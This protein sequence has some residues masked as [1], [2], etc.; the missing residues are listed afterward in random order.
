MPRATSFTLLS[1]SEYAKF[2]HLNPLHFAGGISASVVDN[3]C[4][5]VWKQWSWQ[6]DGKISR[7]R[8]AQLIQEAERDI[9][10]YLGYWPAPVWIEDERKPY[11]RLYRRDLTGY[12]QDNRFRYRNIHLDYGKVLYGGRRAT[13][14]LSPD[15]VAYTLKDLDGDGFTETAEFTLTVPS[16]LDPCEV[17]LYFKEYSAG[18]AENCRTDPSSTG[19]DFRWEIRPIRT[20]LSGTILTI[21]TDSWELFKPQLQEGFNVTAIDADDVDSYVDAV[22]VYREYNDPSLPVQFLWGADIYCDD[23]SGACSWIVQNGCM[24]ID[25]SKLGLVTLSP[26]T[27]N[28]STGSFTASAWSQGYEPDGV[29][30]WYR[31]GATESTS[32]C[33]VLDRFWADTIA[34]LATA[35]LDFP[36]CS[37][38][39]MAQRVSDKWTVDKAEITTARTF[40]APPDLLHCPFGTRAGEYEA[41][42]RIKKR[43]LGRVTLT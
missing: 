42:K 13:E 25:N 22:L 32:D 10:E 5:D 9:V 26:A 4:G 16:T 35:R 39:D 6:D 8:V 41:W 27:Y 7:E 14:L 19:A 28:E 40:Q 3:P 37:C 17:K 38:E 2:L 20:S 36:I 11:P 29:R 1:L 31:A 18:D 43:A 24:R 30:L 15:P 21:W 12:G 34:M 33:S 23:T